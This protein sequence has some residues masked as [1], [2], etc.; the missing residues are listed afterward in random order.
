[1]GHAPLHSNLDIGIILRSNRM[2]YDP[3]RTMPPRHVTEW[4]FTHNRTAGGCFPPAENGS[5]SRINT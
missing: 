2:T 3:S 1:M 5:P 4:S